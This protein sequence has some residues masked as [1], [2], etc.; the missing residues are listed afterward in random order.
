MPFYVKLIIFWLVIFAIGYLLRRFPDSTI[1]RIAFSWHGPSPKDKETLGH[2]M[3]R[4]GLFAFKHGAIIAIIFIVG[5]YIGE[6]INPDIYENTYFQVVFLFGLPILLAMAIL[7][8]VG[9]LIKSAWYSLRR[10]DL[11]F[12]NEKQEFIENI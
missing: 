4:W 10:A 12:S 11:I 6:A 5:I 2:Y 3:M 1:S 9:C 8:G 7:G